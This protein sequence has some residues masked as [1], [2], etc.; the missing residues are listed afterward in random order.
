MRS[1]GE[2]YESGVTHSAQRKLDAG[3]V[4]FR[5]ECVLLCTF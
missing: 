2:K 5:R 1:F 3:V 4:A